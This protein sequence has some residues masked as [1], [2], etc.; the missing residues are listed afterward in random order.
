MA[1]ANEL[2][3]EVAIAVLALEGNK[4]QSDKTRLKEILVNFYSALRPLTT[5]SRRRHVR[6]RV[7]TA[8]P[9]NE[10]TASK[11]R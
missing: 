7:A 4:E 11:D 6:A 1:I 2:S 5:A 8:T 3:G 9:S 10:Q